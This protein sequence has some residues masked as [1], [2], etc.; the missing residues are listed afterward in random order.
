[1]SPLRVIIVTGLSGAGKSTALRALED[2]GFYC[3]DNLP[4][5][6]LNQLLTGLAQQVDGPRR[7][8]VGMDVRDASFPASF[9]ALFSSLLE[10]YDCEV[11]FLEATDAV[12]VQRFSELRRPHPLLTKGTLLAGIKHERNLLAQLCKAAAHRFDTSALSPLALRN[13]IRQRYALAD[14]S[15]NDSLRVVLLS[16]GFKHGVPLEADLLFDVRFLPNPHYVPELRQLTGR[17]AGVATYAL[18]NHEGRRFL[19]LLEEMLVFLLPLYRREGKA[20]LT[21]GIG[22][23][24]G[25]HRSVATAEALRMRLSAGGE[26]V[27]AMHRQLAD[28]GEQDREGL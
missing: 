16:F 11:L 10:L 4:S 24:G 22:C 6:L 19:D 18:E 8:A 17:E 25:R 28:E 9:P 3:V 13:L 5:F 21:V 1:M 23:T 2:I 12:L 27:F 7:V 20:S 15:A 14:D 26:V